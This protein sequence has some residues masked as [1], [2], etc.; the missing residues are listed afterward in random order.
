MTSHL[1]CTTTTIHPTWLLMK[2]AAPWLVT[3]RVLH[4]AVLRYRAQRSHT[5]ISLPLDNARPGS[6]I[7]VA[8]STCTTLPCDES[9]H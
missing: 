6:Y 4:G 3:G 8:P 7:A 2:G 9:P 5:Q 1:Q